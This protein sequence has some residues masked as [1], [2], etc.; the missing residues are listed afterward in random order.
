MKVIQVGLKYLIILGVTLMVAFLMVS[1]VLY[2]THECPE[3]EV[4]IQ[5][6][7]ILESNY[8]K[9]ANQRVYWLEYYQSYQYNPLADQGE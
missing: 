8:A 1:T 5:Q 6:Y 7:Q 3:P 9:C 4:T 2:W